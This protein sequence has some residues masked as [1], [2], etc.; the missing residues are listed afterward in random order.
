M[1][2]RKGVEIFTMLKKMSLYAYRAVMKNKSRSSGNGLITFLE[3]ELRATV[4]GGR[5]TRGGERIDIPRVFTKHFGSEAE[6]KW[7]RTTELSFSAKGNSGRNQRN[8]SNRVG[9]NRWFEG[10]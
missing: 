8:I 2:G 7:A 5:K 3:K 1:I 9:K 4:L 10:L 6:R